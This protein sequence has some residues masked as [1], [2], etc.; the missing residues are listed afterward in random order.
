MLELSIRTRLMLDGMI[1][2]ARSTV[3]GEGGQT[4]AE[5]M[6]IIIFVAAILTAIFALNIDD[7][8]AKAIEA[9]IDKIKSGKGE[10]G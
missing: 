1:E 8:I 7:D 3:R 2:R 4:A 9:A 5:Y 6:G 10:G